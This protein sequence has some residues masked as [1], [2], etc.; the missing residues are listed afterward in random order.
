MQTFPLV[1]SKALV[2][3]RLFDK[4][5]FGVLKEQFSGIILATFSKM[6]MGILKT[7]MNLV[8]S[9]VLFAQFDRSFTS[10]F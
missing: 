8:S 1:T 5:V 2:G 7:R 9:K 6:S 3:A 4:F 10:Q